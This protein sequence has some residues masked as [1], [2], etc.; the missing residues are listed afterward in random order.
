M[1]AGEL[2]SGGC[3]ASQRRCDTGFDA[4]AGSAFLQER[5]K[6]DDR[7]QTLAGPSRACSWLEAPQRISAAVP[8]IAANKG[9]F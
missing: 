2:V 5:E 1:T 4:G 6:L 9:G 8:Q 7:A 3:A